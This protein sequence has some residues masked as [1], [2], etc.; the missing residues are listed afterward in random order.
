MNSIQNPKSKIQNQEFRIARRVRPPRLR[1]NL[2]LAASLLLGACLCACMTESVTTSDGRPMPPTPHS[3]PPVPAGTRATTIAVRVGNRPADTNGNGYPDL[4]QVEAH[5]IAQ[6]HPTPLYQDGS[7]VFALYLEGAAS[8]DDARPI[9]QWRIGAD[10]VRAA[11]TR[12]TIGPAYAFRLSLLDEGTDK[13]PQIAAD[14]VCRF[15]PSDGSAPV[16]A[17][18]VY[19]VQLGR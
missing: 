4:I 5:L 1:R 12:S 9:A 7:F 19:P 2:R 8:S 3:A 13:L 11:R 10:A 17:Q 15:E 6:P 14:L 16:R 18:N